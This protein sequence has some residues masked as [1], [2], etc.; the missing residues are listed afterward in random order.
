MLIYT[1]THSLH[2]YPFIIIS[3]F[4]H[5]YNKYRAS[6]QQLT[7]QVYIVVSVFVE[8]NDYL[9]KAKSSPGADSMQK[10]EL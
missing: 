8:G 5:M 9:L 3:V 2:I 4:T 6:F 7:A 10:Y 1:I